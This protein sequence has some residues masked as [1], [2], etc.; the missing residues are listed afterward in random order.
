MIR[1]L[2]RRVGRGGG[3]ELFPEFGLPPTLQERGRQAGVCI[4][5]EGQPATSMA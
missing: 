5:A 1:A 2:A 3:P 4:Y